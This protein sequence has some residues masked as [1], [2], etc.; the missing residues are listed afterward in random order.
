MTCSATP[1]AA[2]TLSYT[3]DLTQSNFTTISDI[4]F[5]WGGG[6]EDVI[7]TGIPASNMTKNMGAKTLT[8]SGTT[9]GMLDYT[10]TTTGGSGA[11]VSY[12]GTLTP[13]SW[14]SFSCA[15]MVSVDL[16]VSAAGSYEL[17]VYDGGTKVKT[18]YS[19]PFSAGKSNIMF[20]VGDLESGTYTYKLTNG[21]SVV[22]SQTG[23]IVVP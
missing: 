9:E 5:T 1:I 4:V 12:T 21:G 18:I 2:P 19:G 10:V 13:K 16:T 6:A 23:E 14:S 8:I 11:A 17:A 7:V 20:S 22:D 3:G 15:A